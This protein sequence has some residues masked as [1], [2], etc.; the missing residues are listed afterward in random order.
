MPDITM[1]GG[2]G[3]PLRFRCYRFRAETHG[4]QSYFGRAPYSAERGACDQFW[5]LEGLEPSEGDI[6]TRAYFLWETGGRVEGT[7]EED[8][9][10]ARSQLVAEFEGR[11]GLAPPGTDAP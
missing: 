2:E 10:R 6:R 8:W 4:R 3:C 7:H 1:C 5:A 11:L 9:R